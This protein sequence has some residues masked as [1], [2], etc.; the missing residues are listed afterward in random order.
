MN[1]KNLDK[2]QI[3]N[4]LGAYEKV[5]VLEQPNILKYR[6]LQGEMKQHCF[7]GEH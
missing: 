7:T 1:R 3:R 4:F 2:S 6:P 5:E